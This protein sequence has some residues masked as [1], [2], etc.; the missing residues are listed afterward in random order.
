MRVIKVQSRPLNERKAIIIEL[1]GA[2]AKP[3]PAVVLIIHDQAMPVSDR[4]FAQPVLQSRGHHVAGPGD[5]G[6]SRE[7]AIVSP[8]AAQSPVAH[9]H[10]S[11]CARE[12]WGARR[13]F[14]RNMQWIPGVLMMIRLAFCKGIEHGKF[15]KGGCA[16]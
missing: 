9:V 13:G 15:T 12:E 16:K 6:W 14:I 7:T 8:H 4:R 1:A 11:G 3:R 2:D 5:P 10:L